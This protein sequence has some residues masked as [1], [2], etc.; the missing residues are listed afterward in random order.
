MY[1]YY[2]LDEI[3]SKTLKEIYS[4]LI[5]KKKKNLSYTITNLNPPT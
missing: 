5:Q 3:I 4:P 1:Y 2:K